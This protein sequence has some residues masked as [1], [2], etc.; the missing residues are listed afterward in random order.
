MTI[1]LIKLAVGVESFTDLAAWQEQRLRH[2]PELMHIT[3]NTPKRAKEL[4]DGGSLYWVI[5]GWICARQR[6][7]DIR[8]LVHD[9]MPQC[10]LVYDKELVRV[11]PRQHRPFQGWRYLEPAATPADVVKG[12][13]EEDD[14]PEELRRELEVLGVG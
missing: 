6:L 1:H 10:A 7:V 2:A 8:P 5:K 9:G 4:L 12:R 13:E 11:R 14:L 3:R